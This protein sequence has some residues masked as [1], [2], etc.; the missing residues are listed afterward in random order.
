M[1]EG[2]GRL[3]LPPRPSHVQFEFTALT[4]TDSLHVNFRYRLDGFD[5][6]WVDAGSSRQASYTNLPPGNYRFQVMASNGDNVWSGPAATVAFGIRPAFYQTGW[7]YLLCLVGITAAVYLAWHLNARRARQRFALVLAERIRMSRAIH[8]TLLQS[9]VGVA[10]QVD[11]VSSSLEAQESSAR[12]QL[13]RIRRQVEQ[14][15]R[16]ARQSIHDLRS[17]HLESRDLPTALREFGRNALGTANVRFT[18]TASGDSSQSPPK[19]ENQLL[20]IGQEAILNAVRHAGASRIKVTL[21]G[22]AQSVVLTVS[23][24]G[25]GF[26]VSRMATHGNGH[27]GLRMMRERAEELGGR[28]DVTTS[29][30]GGTTV[31][32]GLAHPEKRL[33]IQQVS[34][35]GEER[36]LKGSYIGSCVPL[37]DI[38][39]YV[40]LYRKGRLPV[41][42]LLSE[43]LTHEGLNAGFDRLAIGKTVRQILEP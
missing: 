9:L 8:D 11:V 1:D 26:D 37:R 30:N 41:D 25:R 19:V 31:T 39:R 12:Q 10:L 2:S 40:G 21:E 3:T 35:V 27:Y 36:T 5:H 14:Y 7:F 42:R 34:L 22:H 28:L 18:V 43:R 32:A 13:V 16:D 24:D 33:S 20:R 38:P 29:A 4:L 17:P 23:D 15:I 6:D